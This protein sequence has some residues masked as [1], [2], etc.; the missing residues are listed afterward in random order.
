[1]PLKHDTWIQQIVS[2]VLSLVPTDYETA[3]LM[4]SCLDA[5][6]TSKRNVKYLGLYSTRKQ[7]VLDVR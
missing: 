1:M 6:E 5:A 3:V 7:T 4:D 2:L